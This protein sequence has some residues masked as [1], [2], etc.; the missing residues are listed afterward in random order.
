MATGALMITAAP[1]CFSAGTLNP[2]RTNPPGVRPASRRIPI[3]AASGRSSRG[4]RHFGTCRWSNGL[5]APDGLVSH[6]NSWGGHRVRWSIHSK[7]IRNLQNLTSAIF[8]AALKLT[9]LRQTPARRVSATRSFI[10]GEVDT[11]SRVATLL[12]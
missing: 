6:G 1:T 2:Y 10:L 3:A 8:A 12:R 7:R 11:Q 9:L 5:V 4:P